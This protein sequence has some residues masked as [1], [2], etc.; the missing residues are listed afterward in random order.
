MAKLKLGVVGCGSQGSG[1][2]DYLAQ[3][4]DVTLVGLCDI[5]MS[6]LKELQAEFKCEFITTNYEELL[7]QGLDAILIATPHYLHAPYTIMAAEKGINVFSEKPMAITLQECEAMIA[8]CKENCVKLQIGFQRRF[9]TNMNRIKY[10][11]TSG[12]LG[13][14]YHINCFARWYRD[15]LYFLQSSP[16]RKEDGGK[17]WRGKWKTEGGSAII[18]QT[19]HPI[20]LF[21]WFG[22]PIRDIQASAAIHRHEFIETEDNVG[23]IINFQNGAIGLLQAG[24]VYHGD[25]DEFAIYGT[26]GRLL[27]QNDKIDLVVNNQ[28]Q[29]PEKVLQAPKYPGARP[30]FEDFIK[31]IRE[32]RDPLVNG[33]EAMKAI[34]VVRGIYMSIMNN[35]KVTF[36]VVDNGM[37]PRIPRYYRGT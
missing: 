7:N 37:F 26:K 1:W 28:K 36:P 12:L 10:A 35:G 11:I 18:N 14:V 27:Y 24:V 25:S 22:G 30:I 13:D 4:E 3:H 19:I 16:V 33:I 34:E 21:Q 23:A 17:H 15:E 20:D 8:A 32:D 29:D 31:A 5:N 9:E 2:A 6:K